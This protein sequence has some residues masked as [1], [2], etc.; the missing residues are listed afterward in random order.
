MKKEV[1]NSE[2]QVHDNKIKIIMLDNKEFLSLT[3]LVRYANPEEPKIP[4]Q[5]WMRNKDV[6]AYL[7]LWENW[8]MNTLKVTSL[9]P[10]K[11][12]REKVDYLQNLNYMSYKEKDILKLD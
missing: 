2:I 9:R 6:I 3:D 8:I 11:I 4:I 1:I 12:L 7:G 10:L 5:T